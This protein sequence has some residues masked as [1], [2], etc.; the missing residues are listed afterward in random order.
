MW[1]TAAKDMAVTESRPSSR[2][3]PDM[4]KCRLELL[5]SALDSEPETEDFVV[6]RIRT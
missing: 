3:Y 5:R 1:A 6:R 4:L 2:L